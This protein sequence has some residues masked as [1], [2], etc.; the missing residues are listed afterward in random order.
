MREMV[1]RLEAAVM[2][3]RGASIILIFRLFRS[4]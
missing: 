4:R 1:R 2:Q 3:E